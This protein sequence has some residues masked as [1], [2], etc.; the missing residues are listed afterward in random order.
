[1]NKKDI[2]LLAELIMYSSLIY[3]IGV[4]VGYCIVNQQKIYDKGVEDGKK[5]QLQQDE[6]L[7]KKIEKYNKSILWEE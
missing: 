3:I 4:Y 2:L 1:M 7:Y 6:M 5:Y